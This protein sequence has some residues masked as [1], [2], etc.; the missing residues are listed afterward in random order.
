MP[1]NSFITRLTSS[2]K[3]PMGALRLPPAALS[4][5]RPVSA[6]T[7]RS[8]WAAAEVSIEGEGRGGGGGERERVQQDSH[9][10]PSAKALRG[11]ALAFTP[12]TP[13]STRAEESAPH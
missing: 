3:T 7:P 9:G 10:G 8:R 12:R 1:R 13:W 6:G 2:S 4:E 11:A 5:G